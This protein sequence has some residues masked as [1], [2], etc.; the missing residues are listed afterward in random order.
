MGLWLRHQGMAGLFMDGNGMIRKKKA[1]VFA[2]KRSKEDMDVKNIMGD[3]QVQ[4][5]CFC[6]LLHPYVHMSCF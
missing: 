6:S 2:V 1:D 3:A 5:R 4:T